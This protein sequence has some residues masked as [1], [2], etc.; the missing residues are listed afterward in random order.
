[1]ST[2]QVRRGCGPYAAN[3]PRSGNDR[4]RAVARARRERSLVL[5]RPA[6]PS[7][8]GDAAHAEHRHALQETGDHVQLP[9]AP[10][11]GARYR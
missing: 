10:G 7:V 9:V 4:V 3:E 1:M 2:G 5:P 11:S 8:I 6:A